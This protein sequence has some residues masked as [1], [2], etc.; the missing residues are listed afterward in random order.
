MFLYTNL[1]TKYEH[2]GSSYTRICLKVLTLAHLQQRINRQ[3]ARYEIYGPLLRIGLSR[4]LFC[5]PHEERLFKVNRISRLQ[6]IVGT[7]TNGC[8]ST[9]ACPSGRST[10]SGPLC[11]PDLYSIV[12]GILREI[13]N[14]IG[15]VPHAVKKA[16]M[17]GHGQSI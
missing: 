17:G 2:C 16:R 6:S 11:S 5:Y 7:G 15:S 1:V 12:D 13:T 3:C 8:T 14:L 10:L 9:P 4:T